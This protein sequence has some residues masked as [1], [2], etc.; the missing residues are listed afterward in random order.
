MTDMGARQGP[1]TRLAPGTVAILLTCEGCAAV[2]APSGNG[3]YSRWAKTRAAE[4][5]WYFRRDGRVFCPQHRP[6]YAP[7]RSDDA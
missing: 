7:A 1:P 5:G 4:D 6:S 3:R 2:I